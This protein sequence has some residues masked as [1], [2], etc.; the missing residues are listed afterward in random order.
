[1]IET[2][3]ISRRGTGTV[4]VVS[5]ISKMKEVSESFRKQN[6]TIGFVPTMGCLH[7]GHLKLIKRSLESCDQTVVSIFVNPTQFGPNEDLDSY[8]RQLESDIEK[9]ETSG[10]DIL[11][12]PT[13][14]EMYP[15][16]Y[17]TYVQVQNI[18]GHLCGKSRP[19]FFKGVTTVVLKL[20]NIVRPHN[21]FFGE[22]DA[23]QLRVIE[24]LINA[25]GEE[26]YV[27]LQEKSLKSFTG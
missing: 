19:G 10:V 13:K 4:Q 3:N 14:E 7:Q 21:A 12:H 22:K 5:S 2:E 16:G 23:Q 24:K 8:P 26:V 1:M 18:S 6:L 11:F 27:S 9:L 25:N 17:K 20:F 15:A